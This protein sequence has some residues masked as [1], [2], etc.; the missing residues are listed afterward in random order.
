MYRSGIFYSV[1][2]GVSAQQTTQWKFFFQMIGGAIADNNDG[3][4]LLTTSFSVELWR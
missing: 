4:L 1:V 2:D 3:P